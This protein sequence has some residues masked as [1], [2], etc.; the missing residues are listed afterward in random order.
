MK[1]KF[2]IFLIHII[3]FAGAQKSIVKTVRSAVKAINS[4]VIFNELIKQFIFM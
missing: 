1:T 3:V 4:N 2:Y